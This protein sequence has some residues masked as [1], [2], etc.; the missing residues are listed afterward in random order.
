MR[1]FQK[2]NPQVPAQEILS[3]VTSKAAEALGSGRELGRVRPGHL[4]DLIG[5]PY[6]RISRGR[7]DVWEKVLRYPGQ[8]S[9]AMVHGEIRLRVH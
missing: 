3:L 9:F 1:S 4:A 6:D 8:V 5:I 2:A 7:K